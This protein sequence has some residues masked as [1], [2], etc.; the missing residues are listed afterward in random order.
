M[1]ETVHD[2]ADAVMPN[3]MNTPG[4]K[5]SHT[6]KFAGRRL[7]SAYSEDEH[8]HSVDYEDITSRGYIR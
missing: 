3:V 5:G 1:Q 6:P 7:S 2:F 4:L 8:T